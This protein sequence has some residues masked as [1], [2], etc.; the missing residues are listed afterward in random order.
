MKKLFALIL[1]GVLVACSREPGQV[2]PQPHP[3][4]LYKDLG[5]IAVQFGQHFIVD[6]DGDNTDDLLFST[7]LVGDPIL[8]RDR[9]QYYLSANFDV[10]LSTNTLEQMPVLSDGHSIT[11]V[12][13]PG[14]SWFNASSVLLAEKIIEL[15]GPD[16]WEGNWKN[17]QHKY[18]PLQIRKGQLFFNGWVEVSFDMQ[19]EQLI[20]HRA[21]VSREAGKTVRAGF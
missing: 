13:L 7:M 17:A 21:A 12:S 4:M 6:I 1:A 14:Y 18:I 10:F 5:G 20:L 16:H 2:E 8:K 9:R 15:N 11:Q 3:Q 19:T